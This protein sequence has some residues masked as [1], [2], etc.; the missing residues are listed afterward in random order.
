ME[1]IKQIKQAEAQARQIIEQAKADAVK[2]AEIGRQNRQQD[3]ANAE[4][5][6]KKVTEAA[7][8]AAQKEASTK[9]ESLKAKAANERQQLR[10]KANNKM[11]PAVAKVMEYLRSHSA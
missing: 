3:L 9:V 4:Q 5:Q 7:V 11:P 10:D 8:A 6:R 1:L 2:Q